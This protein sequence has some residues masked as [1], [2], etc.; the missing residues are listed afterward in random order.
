MKKVLLTGGTGFVGENLLRLLSDSKDY[1]FI[2]IGRKP[3]AN[4]LNCENIIVP[5]LCSVKD[6]DSILKDIDIIIHLAARVHQIKDDPRNSLEKY[7]PLNVDVTTEMARAAKRCNVEKFIFLSSVKVMGEESVEPFI[8]NDV[9]NPVDDYGLSKLKAEQ[10]IRDILLENSFYS[11]RAP[12]IYGPNV[13]AN[14][15]QL[16]KIVNTGLPLPFGSFKHKRSFVFVG[17]LVSLIDF[18]MK[19]SHQSGEFFVSDGED[20]SL[21]ELLKKMAKAIN[22]PNRIFKAPPIIFKWFFKVIGKENIYQRLN[23]SLQVNIEETRKVFNWNPPYS[24]DVA[25]EKTFT[26]E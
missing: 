18:I 13:K 23:T 14:F 10:Q 3:V 1:S 2:N 6:W 17:N 8:L 20:L 15:M 19:G 25:L 24:V 16:S 11:I 4:F 5:D 9:P 22:K 26:N 7:K 12:L 21:A